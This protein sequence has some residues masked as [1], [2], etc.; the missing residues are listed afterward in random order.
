MS[1]IPPVDPAHRP[2]PAAPVLVQFTLCWTAWIRP[3]V[4][5][6]MLMLIGLVISQS[7]KMA[8]LI[9]IGYAIVFSAIVKL[10]YDL[11][12]LRRFR[13]Y[14]DQAG[15]WVRRGALGWH[16]R[17]VGM[18]WQDLARVTHQAGLMSWLTGAYRVRI[19]H[20]HQRSAALEIAH[21]RRGD[22]VAESIN[23]RLMPDRFE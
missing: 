6:A 19:I 13:F 16:N 2:L 7:A 12:W 3:L 23:Q 14:S 17:P 9:L 11:Q 22:Q 18:E 20:R 21:I 1:I 10:G 4:L 15:V 5:F 8:E